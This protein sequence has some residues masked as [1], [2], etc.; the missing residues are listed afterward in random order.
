MDDRDRG[1]SR[2]MWIPWAMTSVA[3]LVVAMVAF[4]LGARHEVV[5]GDAVMHTPPTPPIDDA[6][7]QR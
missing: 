3:L 7:G 1:H 2:P 4:A 6:R 5:G